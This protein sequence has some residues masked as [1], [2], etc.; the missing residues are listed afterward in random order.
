MS[1]PGGLEGILS[2][3][4]DAPMVYATLQQ[5]RPAGFGVCRCQKQC[6]VSHLWCAAYL[7]RG[8]RSTPH[9]EVP[10]KYVVLKAEHLA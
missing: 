2:W 8:V 9:C 6:K 5:R 1:A 10:L 3:Q 4:Q 7:E